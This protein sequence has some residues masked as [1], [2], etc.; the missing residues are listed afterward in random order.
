VIP[1]DLWTRLEQARADDRRGHALQYRRHRKLV[2]Y[3][4]WYDDGKLDYGWLAEEHNHG[5]Q[6]RAEF[7]TL[8]DA[9]DAAARQRAY[10]PETLFFAESIDGKDEE[11]CERIHRAANRH[12]V[13]R[14]EAELKLAK[15]APR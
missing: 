15:K 2:N 10:D 14:L 8:E 4:V 11:R 9:E 5:R 3:G 7:L 12:R 6:Y 13:A 1:A